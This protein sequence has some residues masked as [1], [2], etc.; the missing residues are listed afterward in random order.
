MAAGAAAV[1]G[2]DRTTFSPETEE[3]EAEAVIVVGAEEQKA[4]VAAEAY[5]I[6][7]H[8]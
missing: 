3:A 8:R 2:I 7:T 1:T 4:L 6:L 5:L